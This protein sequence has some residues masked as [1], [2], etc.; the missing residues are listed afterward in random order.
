MNISD[1]IK[2]DLLSEETK[3]VI[4]QAWEEA[5]KAESTRLETEYQ[6][7]LAEQYDSAISTAVQ[8]VEESMKEELEPLKEEIQ[9]ARSLEVKYAQRLEDFKEQYAAKMDERIEQEVAEG[10]EAHYTE[11]EEKF[12]QLGEHEFASKILSAFREDYQQTFATE[13]EA[14]AKELV[15]ENAE[16]KQKLSKIERDQKM[17]ELTESL[18]ADKKRLAHNLL[19]DVPVTQLEAKFESFLPF[20]TE[21]DSSKKEEAVTEGEDDKGK[22]VDLNGDNVVVEEETHDDKSKSKYNAEAS[23]RFAKIGL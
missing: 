4:S 20:L 5:M 16:L 14:S 15:A 2:S 19:E 13:S 7:K 12:K 17:D 8:M 23:R 18:S 11:N 9:H 22:G 21:S 10:L 6:E 1:L 3:Q